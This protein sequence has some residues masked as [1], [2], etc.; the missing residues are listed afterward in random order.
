MSLSRLHK[1]IEY[2]SDVSTLNVTLTKTPIVLSDSKARYLENEV[3]RGVERRIIWWGESGEPT[4]KRLEYLQSN[5]ELELH[6]HPRIVL[7]IFLGTCDLTVIDKGL[8]EL[9]SKNNSSAYEL[10]DKF[11]E[12]Y[13][14]LRDFPTVE[15]VLL[16]VPPYSVF[17][18]NKCRGVEDFK[19]KDDDKKLMD[20][21]AIVNR[22]VR[23]TNLIYRKESPK[24]GLD[25]ENTR[26]S[27][28]DYQ[29]KY[30]YRFTTFYIDGTHPIPHLARLWLLRICKL[31]VKDCV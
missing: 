8:V 21:I 29:A 30:S 13:K 31:V 10:I 16:E 24:F 25:L 19:Y 9:K 2:N 12:V 14:F 11:R 1:Q 6:R 26:K 15:P 18:T 3:I 22:F 27:R 5:L 28:Y 17:E 20:Q 4:E 23:E 7:Y